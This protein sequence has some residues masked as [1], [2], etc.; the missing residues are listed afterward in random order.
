LLVSKIKPDEMK[1]L[2]FLFFLFYQTGG[3][4]AQNSVDTLETGTIKKNA[5]DPQI[6]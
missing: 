4:L 3:L 2:L 6:F 5:D 1:K